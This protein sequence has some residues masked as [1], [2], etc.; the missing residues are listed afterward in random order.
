MVFV[1]LKVKYRFKATKS[2]LIIRNQVYIKGEICNI[3]NKKQTKGFRW[4]GY[5][6][7]DTL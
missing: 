6:I 5:R 1:K 7:I 3:Y 4:S 2:F